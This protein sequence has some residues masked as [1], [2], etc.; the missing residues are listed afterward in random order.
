MNC[1][2]YRGYTGCFEYDSEADIFHGE[3]LDLNDVITFQGRSIDELKAAL[4]DSVED[5]LEFCTT[6]G[7]PRK[8]LIPDVSTCVLPLIC[9]GGQLLRREKTARASTAGSPMSSEMPSTPET[10]LFCL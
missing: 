9:I 8:S 5:Y 1:L 6:E 3:V 7:K 2:N 10:V 4:K